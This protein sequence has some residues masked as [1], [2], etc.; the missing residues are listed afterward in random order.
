M[1]FGRLYT[2]AQSGGDEMVILRGAFPTVDPTVRLAIGLSIVLLLIG[3]PLYRAAS[4]LSQQRRWIIFTGMLLL[5]FVLFLIVVLRIANPLL[6][7]GFLA[8]EGLLGSPLFV[9]IWTVFWAI[10]LLLSWRQLSTT[11]VKR[12]VLLSKDQ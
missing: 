7:S 6:A 2:V 1:P 12:G 9:N 8:S 4:V 10:V 11:L 5:P 3:P